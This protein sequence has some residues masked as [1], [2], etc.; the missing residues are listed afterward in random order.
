MPPT[1]QFSLQ[2]FQMTV[3][4]PDKTPKYLTCT[5]PFL[6][7]VCSAF[8]RTQG[9]SGKTK[10]SKPLPE[11]WLL[12]I[13]VPTLGQPGNTVRCVKVFVNPK[14][15]FRSGQHQRITV[16]AAVWSDPVSARHRKHRT[17]GATVKLWS[18]TS[19]CREAP[20]S[21]LR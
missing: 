16:R 19:S 11:T 2:G 1:E 6:P 12:A 17:A 20:Q 13:S 18:I 8:C 9:T 21:L 14:G 7:P 3:L 15:M 5:F 4:L 10:P